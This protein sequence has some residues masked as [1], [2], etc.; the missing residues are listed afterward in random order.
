MP[1]PTETPWQM[2]LPEDRLKWTQTADPSPIWP[3]EP[4]VDIIRNIV[5]SSIPTEGDD[6][7]DQIRCD[8]L[9]DGAHH[10]IYNVTHPSWTTPYL[11]RVAIPVDPKLK[12]ESEMATL[13]FLRQHTS[14]PVPRPI[15][16]CSTRTVDNKLGYEWAILEKLPGVELRKVW[17]KVPWEK[18]LVLIENLAKFRTQ[19]WDSSLK[20]SKIGSIYKISNDETREGV[21]I[22]PSVDGNFYAGRRRYLTSDRGPFST[23][24]EWLRAQIEIE[25]EFLRTAKILANSRQS[26][27]R[28]TSDAEWS[29]LMDEIGVDQDTLEEYDDVMSLCDIFLELLPVLF[30]LPDQPTGNQ[31][32]FSLHHC[33]LR[34][35]NILVDPDTFN[36]TGIID[37]EQTCTVPDWYGRDYPMM[38]NT[39][40]P[41]DAEEPSIPETYD[42]EDER[43]NPA[44]VSNRDRWDSKLLREKFDAEL[45]RLGWEGW[46]SSSRLDIVKSEFIQGV[47]DLKKDLKLV[48]ALPLANAVNQQP[49]AGVNHINKLS[50]SPR[51]VGIL[52]ENSSAKNSLP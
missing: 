13:Q 2:Y 33:D 3:F 21:R 45:V 46:H 52:S 31:D 18:K 39:D 22:G 41:F 34:E 10:K 43:Y 32:R 36:L 27:G 35:A 17:R 28:T 7:G 38:I 25:R 44:K 40:E 12:L 42:E 48:E 24:H 9:A 8:F 49:I 14:I 37:W 6:P 11:F 23:C 29:D 51:E 16:W 1:E 15:R 5:Q 30:P 47:A 4:D 19:I 26:L 20:F 50:I